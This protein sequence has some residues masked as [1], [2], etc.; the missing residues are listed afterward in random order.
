MIKS[1]W[2]TSLS[3]GLTAIFANTTFAATTTEQ[4][5]Q[6]TRIVQIE[7]ET[8]LCYL[9]TSDGKV[10]NLNQLCEQ[11]PQ[12]TTARSTPRIASPYNA[13]TIKRFDDDLYGEGN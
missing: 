9:Q 11:Q 3:I 13:S 12:E 1:L 7:P 2:L 8:P 5:S 10:W 4:K 6:P